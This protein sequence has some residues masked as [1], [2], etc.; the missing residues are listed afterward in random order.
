MTNNLEQKIIPPAWS[1]RFS[2]YF[3][4]LKAWVQES[5]YPALVQG[6]LRLDSTVMGILAELE[7]LEAEL[8]RSRPIPIALVGL[9]GV[10]KS[11]LLNAVLEE[12]FLPVGVIGSQTAAFV[13]ISYAPE[14]EVTCEYIDET[15]LE[16]IFQ[17][18]GQEVDEQNET[19][20]PEV[21][22][23]AEKKARALLN[24]TDETRLPPRDTLRNGAPMEL[25]EIVAA[26][27]RRFHSASQ[28]KEQLNL[29]AKGKLWPITTAIDVRGPFEHVQ[30]R[31]LRQS[32]MPV[33]Y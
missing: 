19:G 3:S 28:W 33:R 23:K 25:R 16:R 18:A 7:R 24:L 5:A 29:H 20:S 4:A 6:P 30:I 27:K 2:E 15:E 26:R 32:R 13:T 17:E 8:L 31:R 9:T 1:L 12:E 10:G 21:R 14:W 11:T 22:E